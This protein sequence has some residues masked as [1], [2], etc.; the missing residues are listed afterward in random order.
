M[1]IVMM[2]W[3]D[4]NSNQRKDDRDGGVVLSKVGGMNGGDDG[5]NGMNGGDGDGEGG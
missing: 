4:G 5:N 2:V 3:G 1:A